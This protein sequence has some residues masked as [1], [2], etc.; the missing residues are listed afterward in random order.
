MTF[1]H[2]RTW[3]HQ[4][5]AAFVQAENGLSGIINYCHAHENIT[6]IA[7]SVITRST[8][9]VHADMSKQFETLSASR[10]EHAEILKLQFRQAKEILPIPFRRRIDT[11]P[12]KQLRKDIQKSQRECALA[13]STVDSRTGQLESKY[14]EL[15]EDLEAREARIVDLDVKIRLAEL[16]ERSEMST[17]LVM[18]NKGWRLLERVAYILSNITNAHLPYIIGFDESDS[19]PEYETIYRPERS[20]R[21][22]DSDGHSDGNL[23]PYPFDGRRRRASLKTK[24]KGTETGAQGAIDIPDERVWGSTTVEACDEEFARN[25]DKALR[26]LDEF[27]RAARA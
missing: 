14:R 18:E 19:E 23:L 22:S 21:D 5:K 25:V 7:Q 4:H 24:G 1:V 17:D 13:V 11:T 27:A 10:S 6:K 8:D 16:G 20:D 2:S 26:G 12:I 15:R 9:V 3:Y